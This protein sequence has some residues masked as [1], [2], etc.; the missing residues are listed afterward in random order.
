[1]RFDFYRI[2]RTAL[3]KSRHMFYT[4]TTPVKAAVIISNS[5]TFPR[6]V[7]DKAEESLS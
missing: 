7:G 1:M 4:E 2:A 6:E 3:A 5:T